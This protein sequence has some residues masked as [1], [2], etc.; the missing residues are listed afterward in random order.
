MSGVQNDFAGLSRWDLC[1]NIVCQGNQD[2]TK[3][4]SL[5]Q[6][7]HAFGLL[8]FGG[9]TSTLQARC[10]KI[11]TGMSGEAGIPGETIDLRESKEVHNPSPV[12]QGEGGTPKP[13]SA[14][15]AAEPVLAAPKPVATE[16]VTP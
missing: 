14:P 15:A 13:A 7:L 9:R 10:E 4:L 1:R 5:K 6:G 2:K 3:G 8:C 12:N 11:K 16:P